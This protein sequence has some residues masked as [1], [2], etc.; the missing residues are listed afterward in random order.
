MPKMKLPDGCYL[1]ED[2]DLRSTLDPCVAIRAYG[3]PDTVTAVGRD[4]NGEWHGGEF[5]AASVLAVIRSA[6]L[7]PVYLA[8]KDLIETAHTGLDYNADASTWKAIQALETL[9]ESLEEP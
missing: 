5:P 2:G 8:A 3:S 7:D 6:N 4:P 9:L 1:D